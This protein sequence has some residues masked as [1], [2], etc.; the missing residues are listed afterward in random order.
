MI[1]TPYL[2]VMQSNIGLFGLPTT[3]GSL[4]APTFTAAT[5]QPVPNVKD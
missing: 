3:I 4:S 5:I 1:I 2:S